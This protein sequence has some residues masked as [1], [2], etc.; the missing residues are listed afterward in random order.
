M[1]R[2]CIA[3]VE[4]FV[5]GAAIAALQKVVLVEHWV[6]HMVFQGKVDVRDV[7]ADGDMALLSEGQVF[8][9]LYNTA[10]ALAHDDNG[11]LRAHI[12]RDVLVVRNEEA[13]EVAVRRILVAEVVDTA[14]EVAGVCFDSDIHH[15]SLVI[16]YVAFLMLD[17]PWPVHWENTEKEMASLSRCVADESEADGRHILHRRGCRASL[18]WNRADQKTLFLLYYHSV[19]Y[20]TLYYDQLCT[21]EVYG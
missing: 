13:V 3:V 4:F 15:A 17:R 2:E 9:C 16:S 14:V 20:H 6:K 21:K 5:A 12:H 8:H 11:P 1:M 10:V 7:D 18:A 19:A